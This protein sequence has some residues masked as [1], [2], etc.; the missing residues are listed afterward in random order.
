MMSN[1]FLMNARVTKR[2]KEDIFLRH[3]RQ[4]NLETEYR[5]HHSW[6]EWRKRKV[7]LRL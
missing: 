3:W 5:Q 7:A 2:E 6:R 1:V 4:N